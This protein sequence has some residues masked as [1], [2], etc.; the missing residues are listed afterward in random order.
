[1]SH[2]NLGTTVRSPHHVA[3]F[4]RDGDHAR[5]RGVGDGAASPGVLS[6][7]GGASRDVKNPAVAVSDHLASQQGRLVE[8]RAFP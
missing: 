8:T 5:V 3:R 1:L 7:R 2:A 4:A 6:A